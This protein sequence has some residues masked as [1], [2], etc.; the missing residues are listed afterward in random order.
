MLSCAPLASGGWLQRQAEAATSHPVCRADI[1][2][3]QQQQ[4]QRRQ[5]LRGSH[6][7]GASAGWTR[8]SPSSRRRC[9]AASSSRRPDFPSSGAAQEQRRSILL[10]YVDSVQPSFID[11]FAEQAPAPVGHLSRS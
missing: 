7:R 10:Q 5:L 11:K 1:R 9:C 8:A 2:W 6:K 3:P 4:Q